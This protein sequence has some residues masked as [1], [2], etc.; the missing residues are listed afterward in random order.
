MHS[1]VRQGSQRGSE[2]KDGSNRPTL[3]IQTEPWEEKDLNYLTLTPR[4]LES[5]SEVMSDLLRH[6]GVRNGDRMLIY[7]FNTSLSTLVTSRVFAPCLKEGA[8]EKI[9]YTAI[10]TDGLSELAAR[11]AYVFTR[12]NPNILLIRSDLLAP[13]LSKIPSGGLQR[14]NNSLRTVIVSH[15]DV[16]PW[17]RSI[18]LGDGDLERFILYRVDRSKFICIIK[19]CGGVHF[20]PSS[21]SVCTSQDE[22]IDNT[23]LNNKGKE[24]GKIGRLTISPEFDSVGLPLVSSLCCETN[25]GTCSCGEIHQ[26]K[27]V[28]EFPIL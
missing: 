21:Y 28:E 26:F 7:D 17:P 22:D 3:T 8:S 24:S 15:A 2:H 9:G 6:V 11:T 1:R 19:S 16:A 25:T 12:W 18:R 13:F 5:L 20:S 23:G 27:M 4:D 10:C 14:S